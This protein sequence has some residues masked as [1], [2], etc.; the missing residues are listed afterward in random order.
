MTAGFPV[1]NNVHIRE[2]EKPAVIDR[3]Y[4]EESQPRR[5]ASSLYQK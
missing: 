5:R 3:R 4:N 1:S 2:A